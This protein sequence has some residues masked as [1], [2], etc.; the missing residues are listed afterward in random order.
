[1]IKLFI[2][3]FPLDIPEIELAVL[4][5]PHGDIDTLK[6]VR[7]KKTGTCKGYAFVEMKTREG[8]EL[9]MEALDGQLIEDRELSVRFAVEKPAPAAPSRTNTGYQKTQQYN[10]PAKKKRPRRVPGS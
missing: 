10:D 2:G 4:I 5:A 3:G 1:M 9:A 8:A 7:D 6:I